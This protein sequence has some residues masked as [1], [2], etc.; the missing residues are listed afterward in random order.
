M[1]DQYIVSKMNEYLHQATGLLVEWLNK[2]LPKI[3]ENWWNVCV[4]DRLGF[5]QREIAIDKGFSELA[6]FDLAAV[7]RIADK[8]WYS[9]RDFAYLPNNE[10]ECIK[11]MRSVRN[12][13]A[14]CAGTLPGKDAIIHD[15]EIIIKFFEQMGA[16]RD[17]I[18]Q[19]RGFKLNVEHENIATL[20]AELEAKTEEMPAELIM[21][22]E[23]KEKDTVYLVGDPK[24]KGMVFSVEDIGNTTKYEVFVDGGLRTFYSGQV[25]LVVEKP[26][27]N[28]IDINTF[29][30][31]LTAYEINNPSAGN[32]YS[33]NSAR[34]DFVPYQFRPA[35]KMI[36]ADEPRILIAD[37]VGVGKTIEA[38]LIIKELEARSELDNVVVICPKPLVSERK[39]ELE[40]KRF[41][42]DFIPLD[43]KTFRVV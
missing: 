4:L 12:N 6:D 11:D 18:R 42:E 13:W 7:L 43:G 25:A 33:L 40:M 9:M 5:R 19:I 37:S 24:T 28:W 10:R 8:N 29:Q 23:I 15:I 22:G 20:T 17:N 2:M 39:W 14:H 26:S 34:V 27:Y 35:L 1:D 30:S 41:D 3:T 21:D 16:S 38:G 36:K 31:Y 32:L